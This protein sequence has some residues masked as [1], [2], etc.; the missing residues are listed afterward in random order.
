[1]PDIQTS[2]VSRA[3]LFKSFSWHHAEVPPSEKKMLVEYAHDVGNGMAT[4][5]SLMEFNE[6]EASDDRPLLS[7]VDRG[8]LLRLAITT[9]RMLAKVAEEQIDAAN[10]AH[11]QQ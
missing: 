5:L 10:K 3:R 4:L 7:A 9:S 1:M 8:A 11:L 6:I 2:E